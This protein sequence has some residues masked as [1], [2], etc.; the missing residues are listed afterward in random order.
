MDYLRLRVLFQEFSKK[1]EEQHTYYLD[2]VV[3]FSVLHKRVL[4]EQLRTKTHLGN[5]ELTN[6]DFLDTCSTVYSEL[7]DKDF[8]PVSLSP[9]M[10]QGDVKTRTKEN[11]SNYFLLGAN[12]LVALYAYWEEYLRV[13]IG[14]AKGV[15][16]KGSVINDEARKILNKHVISNIWGDIRYLRHSMLH[17]NS[18]ANKDVARCKILKCF[19]PGD[20]IKLDFNIM[21][22]IF[23]RLA[24]YRNELHRMSFPPR[25]GIKIPSS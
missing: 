20:S 2:S 15:L 19:S 10:K 23:F 14:I 5:N 7:S 25:K 9:V 17:N 11:G 16:K 13:E 4:A 18:I 6:D 24:S 1:L 3:G 22:A 8:T 21:Q 12:C